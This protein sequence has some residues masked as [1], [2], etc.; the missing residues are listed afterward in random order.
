MP[1]V[2]LPEGRSPRGGV[3][4]VGVVG[5]RLDCL[6]PEGREALAAAQ[7]VVAGHRLLAAWR[8]QAR[9]GDAARADTVEIG[10]DVDAVASEVRRRAVDAGELVCVLASGDP[11]FFGIARALLR[12]VGRRALRIVPAPSSVSLAFARVGLPWDDAMV[13]SVHGRDLVEAA[14]AMRTAAKVAVLTSPSAPPE[15]VGA[16]MLEAGA[17]ADLVAVCSR[18]GTGDEEVRELSLAELAAGRFD[19]LSVVVLVGPAGLPLLGWSPSTTG[20]APDGPPAADDKVLAWS[21]GLGRLASRRAGM[22]TKPEV[23][24]VVLG[25]LDLP[26]A[27]VLWDVGAGTGSVGIECALARPGLTVL[28]VEQSAEAAAAVSAGSATA[29]VGVHVVHGRAPEVL[30]ELPPPDRAFV[31]GGGLAVLRAVLDRLRPGGRLV[32]TFAAMDRAVAAAALLGNVVELSVSR[33]ET[34]PD[35]GLRLAAHNPVFVVWGPGR[36]QDGAQ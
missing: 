22:V 1:D 32:A 16:A 18:L 29:G 28:A 9:A 33:G 30:G 24:S 14:R 21:P 31:G 26:A 7:V 19:P 13:V 8:A 34:L 10:A 25:K 11:G 17:S 27:G 15:A 23:R 4:V 35:G 20:P 36:E 5:D 6:G 2:A 3:T 12:A